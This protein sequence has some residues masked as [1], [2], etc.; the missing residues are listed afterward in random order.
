MTVLL[1]TRAGIRRQR[2]I[3]HSCTGMRAPHVLYLEL[4]VGMNTPAIIKFPFWAYTRQNKN[5]FY[6]C[7]NLGAAGCS[8]ISRR[9]EASA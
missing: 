1:R 2:G 7:V 6:A 3:R 9:T 8:R 5:A 4:G